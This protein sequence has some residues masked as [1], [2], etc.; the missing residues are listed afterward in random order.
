MAETEYGN[1]AVGAPLRSGE[2]GRIAVLSPGGVGGLLAGLLARDGR[3]VAVVA[4]DSTA[5]GIAE[6][7]LRIESSLFGDFTAHPPA[8]PRLDGRAGVLFVGCKAT[9]LHEALER[10]PAEAVRGALVVPLLNG[11]EHMEAL[12][13]AYPD[14]RV[15]GAAIRVESTR[16]EPGRI[17]QSSPFAS[18]DLAAEGVAGDR[19]DALVQ[20]VRATGL[21]VNVRESEAEVLWKKLHF[22]LPTAL[23]CTHAGRPIGGARTDRR[24]DLLGVAAEVERVAEQYGVDLDTGVV[25]RMADGIPAETKPSML[26]DREAGR[27]MEVDALGGAFLRRARAA[28][29]P[30]P[31]TERIVADLE[32]INAALTAG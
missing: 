1:G 23:V 31:T 10:V 7:G 30:A 20:A 15:A 19:F 5:A 27:P 11:L 28:G 6:R 16:V 22:L 2:T 12:R 29:V 25:Q 18:L 24:D 8:S 13:R 17:V 32:R 9:A 4:T 21:E 26:R 3:D 14:A